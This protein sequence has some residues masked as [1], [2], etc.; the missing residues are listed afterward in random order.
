ML[1]PL[2]LGFLALAQLPPLESFMSG[3]DEAVV[4]Q[5]ELLVVEGDKDDSEGVDDVEGGGG[6]V[7]MCSA[8]VCDVIVAAGKDDDVTGDN[9]CSVWR[10]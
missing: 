2:P 4:E 3:G 8:A 6:D 7:K 1:P 5:N 10:G 9:L